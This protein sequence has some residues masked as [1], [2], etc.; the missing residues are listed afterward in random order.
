ML[1][2]PFSIWTYISLFHQDFYFPFLL[3]YYNPFLLG[4]L[5]P[6]S[7]WTSISLFF[8]DFYILFL[9]VSILL[10]DLYCTQ[11]TVTFWIFFQFW[12]VFYSIYRWDIQCA[13]VAKQSRGWSDDWSSWHSVGAEFLNFH[14]NHCGRNWRRWTQT[15]NSRTNAYG[16]QY[17]HLR[18]QHAGSHDPNWKPGW[19][20]KS[21]LRSNSTWHVQL[22]HSYCLVSSWGI[23]TNN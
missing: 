7:I 12:F 3:D 6:F 18:D 13:M 16:C 1:S 2:Y 8:L 20:W 15:E 19:V 10:L 22:G 5:F 14:L 4:L 9:L 17:W 21:L 11:T 23:L